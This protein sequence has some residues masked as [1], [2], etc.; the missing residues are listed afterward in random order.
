[1]TFDDNGYITNYNTADSNYRD[2]IYYTIDVDGCS[3]S[4]SFTAYEL[5][6][7]DKTGLW[8]PV[9]LNSKLDGYIS[10]V[11]Y[12]YHEADGVKTAL[13][14]KYGANGYGIYVNGTD[15]KVYDVKVTVF[16]GEEDVTSTVL[17]DGALAQA[18][19]YKVQYEINAIYGTAFTISHNVKV[20][21]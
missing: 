17:A 18:G 13:E 7:N 12:I 20:N 10:Y 14:F 11:N 19:T 15:T 2:K 6:A 21:A 1:M 9:S 5:Y 4:N 3:Y 8:G 16:N